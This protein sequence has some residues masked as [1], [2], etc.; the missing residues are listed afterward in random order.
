MMGL[1]DQELFRDMARHDEG[2]RLLV[3]DDATGKTIG[4]GTTVIGNPTIGIG[5]NVGPGGPG[6]R[7]VEMNLMLVNDAAH[8]SEQAGVFD[9]FHDLDEIRA[10]VVVT[11]IFNMGFRNFCTFKNTIDILRLVNT[12]RLRTACSSPCGP[13]RWATGRSGCL[14]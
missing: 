1:I 2:A 3:Y 4:P 11:M 10:T 5:R 12:C 7:D 13:S 14:K 6:L 8:Y 9:W